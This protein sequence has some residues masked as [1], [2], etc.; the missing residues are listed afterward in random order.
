MEWITH[1]VLDGDHWQPLPIHGGFHIPGGITVHMIMVVLCAIFM[2]ILFCGMYRKQ[3]RVP[4][5]LT[6]LLEVLILFVRDEICIP[7]MG[8]ADG[9]KFTPV[10]LTMFFF[11]L[12][13]NVMGLI[14]LF[15]TATGNILVTG[16]L[17]AIVLGMMFIGGMVRNGPIGFFKA[18]IPHGV[19]PAVLLIITPIEFAGVFVK[20]FALMVRL[21]ANMFAGHIIIFCLLGLIAMFGV[22]GAPALLLALGIYLLEIL[23]AALQAY[24]FTL[25]SAMFTGMILHPDH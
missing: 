16:A 3:D 14:P 2:I 20:A 15:S 23:V 21:F 8:E 6:N 19:P 4:T 17:S 24:V 22:L 12:G 9:R 7:S 13:M 18:F 11:I 5:G 25:L 10:F 1:H